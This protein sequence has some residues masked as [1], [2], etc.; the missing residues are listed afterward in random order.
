MEREFPLE[1]SLVPDLIARVVK[2]VLGTAW[3]MG[4][5]TNNAN[6][7]LSDIATYV[8]RNMKKDFRDIIEDSE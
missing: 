4:D 3:R 8:R 6:D 1:V 2:D 7:D 5:N